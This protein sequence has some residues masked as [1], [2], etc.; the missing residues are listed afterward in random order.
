MLA[1]KARIP[2]KWLVAT[3]V[4]LSMV[5][6]MMDSTMVNVAI[7]T[8]QIHFGANVQNVQWVM[9]AY[10]LSQAIV[11]PTAPYLSTNFGAKR[12]Y[13]WTLAAFLLGT[14]LCGFAWNLPSLICFRIF[15][16]IGG[17][18][19]LPMVVTLLYQ[20]FPLEERGIATSALGIP[21]MLTSAV[22]PL[23]G[24]YLVTYLGW[25]WVF[26]I[27]VPLGIIVVGTTQLAL[28]P[29][30]PGKQ[31]KFDTAGF[32]TAAYGGAAF[33]YTLSTIANSQNLAR[34]IFLGISCAISLGVF[35]RIET[36][37]AK[38]G[39]E[40]L[41]DLKLFKDRTFSFGTITLLLSFFIYFGLL[42]LL[43]IYLQ[44]L[45]HQD[46]LHAGMI[47]MTQA[48]AAMA[49]LPISGKLIDIIGPR[50][51]SIVGLIL[52][53]GA[54]L[55]MTAFSLD[56]PIWII[57]GTLILLGIANG[58]SQSTQVAAIS[59]IHKPQEIANGTTLITVLRSFAAS[60][61]IATL[62]II[63]Q[64]RSQSYAQA[65]ATQHIEGSM[66]SQQS[67]ILAMHECFLLTS[68]VALLAL[69]TMCFVPKQR[70]P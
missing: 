70:K 62:S 36:I 14:F 63:M 18:I 67:S 47:L 17:G 6:S 58:L 5:M 64:A 61:G 43:S 53:V 60:M 1:L 20:S 7:P 51:I 57:E 23:V 46:A 50:P 52:F 30:F 21:M 28:K 12:A 66:L 4:S 59:R 37:Q 38:R 44:T 48:L 9:T 56:T 65:L 35:V 2:Y 42:F 24:G 54:T 69:I 3:T 55:M 41:L 15:Q 19:F 45:R 39:N 11:I 27:N 31:T 49:V 22:G 34:T 33:L 25:Q 29:D 16:G 10:I 26:F 32:L 13:V 40:P 68:L 8:M